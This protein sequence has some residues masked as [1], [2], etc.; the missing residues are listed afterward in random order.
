M[1]PIVHRS[2]EVADKVVY[3]MRMLKHTYNMLVERE[4]NVGNIKP[5]EAMP[6]TFR[7]RALALSVNYLVTFSVA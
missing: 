2:K 5:G 4:I 1:A 3:E 6:P 7:D